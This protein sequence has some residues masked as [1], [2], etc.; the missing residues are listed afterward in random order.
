[1]LI[2]CGVLTGTEDAAKAMQTVVSDIIQTTGQR[3]D[4][5]VVTHEHWDH[6]S[7][8]LQAK[9]QFKEL[10]IGQVWLAWT[11]D[12][13]CELANQLR[14]KKRKAHK[15]VGAAREK[16]GSTGAV[17]A[18]VATAALYSLGMF[19]G[20]FSASGRPTTA[21]A[22]DWAR[23]GTGAPVEYL[24][25]GDEPRAI[26]GA[27]GVRV[28]VLGPP[29]DRKLLKRSDP[30]KRTPEVYHLAG[31]L[32]PSFMAALAGPGEFDTGRPFDPSFEK[33]VDEAK[34]E[35]FFRE[36]YYS[37]EEWRQIELDW[38][39]MAELLALRLD[40][41]TN[42][43]SLVLAIELVDSGRVLLFPGDAQ[44]G[45]W[46]SWEP[47]TW[48]LEEPG[49]KRTV[50]TRDLLDRTVLYKVGHHGSHNATLQEK[51]LELM[52]SPELAAMIPVY[53]EQARRQGKK[54]WAMPFG[55]LLEALQERA[56]DRI[57]RADQA[58][59]GDLP[60]PGTVTETDLYIDYTISSQ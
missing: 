34:K 23:E 21:G 30:S 37:A 44:V 33:S 36:F 5:L 2:D 35:N 40:S 7:G 10:S 15:A 11:E 39:G 46:L 14:E 1:M 8:F 31:G 38:L 18:V 56:Q 32:E 54:G 22:M 42:N 50:K 24:S 48:T 59:P 53:E 3:L 60:F 20:A 47:L 19:F 27:E 55:P 29:Q 6:V 41:D 49:G 9:E 52:Q 25:P 28:Y 51:G 58:P 17:G 43:T 12:P 13:R 4:V 45:N 57:L 26:P 16:M